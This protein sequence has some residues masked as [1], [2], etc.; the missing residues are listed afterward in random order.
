MPRKRIFWVSRDADPLDHRYAARYHE[1][2]QYLPLLDRFFSWTAGSRDPGALDIAANESFVVK[3]GDS[4]DESSLPTTRWLTRNMNTCLEAI[5]REYLD[6]ESR[7]A[8]RAHDL[9][10]T[11][12]NIL[13]LTA[14]LLDL[15]SER[16]K[17]AGE[18][19][20]QLSTIERSVAENGVDDAIVLGRRQ[21][22]WDARVAG[23]DARVEATTATIRHLEEQ[24]AELNALVQKAFD[25]AATRARG[26]HAWYERRASVYLRGLIHRHPQGS[27]LQALLGSTDTIP[28]PAWISKPC[29]WVPQAYLPDVTV[30]SATTPNE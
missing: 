15:H 26:A 8:R 20:P 22:V 2:S 11:H 25:I 16:E 7:T 29:P 19:K 24:A 6:G 30:A 18:P 5:E 13:R 10:Q 21:K 27:Q 23:V 28:T 3:N 14:D 4:E 9:D 1:T 17:V 12:R